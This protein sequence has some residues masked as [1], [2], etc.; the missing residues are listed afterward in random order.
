[1]YPL[2]HHVSTMQH[3]YPYQHFPLFTAKA[4]PFT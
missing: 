1:M 2:L 4:V 3:I